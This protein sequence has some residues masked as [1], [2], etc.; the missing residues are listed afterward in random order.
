MEISDS[1]NYLSN[2]KKK[3]GIDELIAQYYIEFCSCPE[4]LLQIFLLLFIWCPVTFFVFYIRS[5]YKKI[6]DIDEDRKVLP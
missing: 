5:P 3:N 4:L 2:E 1:G 6:I